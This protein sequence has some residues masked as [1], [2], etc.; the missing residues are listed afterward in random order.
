M[1]PRNSSA[2]LG[3]ACLSAIAGF[4]ALPGCSKA[5][6][7]APAI[8]VRLATGTTKAGDDVLVQLS[9]T[10]QSASAVLVGF[11]SAVH[12]AQDTW[13]TNFDIRP[14]FV[15]MAGPG[16]TASAVTLAAREGVI[17]A[18]SPLQVPRPFQLEPV[19]FPSRTGIAG[20]VDDT[21][22]RLV[23]F[24]DGS[25]RE[26]YLGRSFFVSSPW[27]DLQTGPG[28]AANGTHPVRSDWSGGIRVRDLTTS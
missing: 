4:C 5:K 7:P 19:C 28:G 27:I 2:R 10:N 22:D 18:W 15:G 14:R 25:P 11:R 12:R 21:Q 20:V 26:S 24:K 16:S 13:V 3:T 23:Q 1:L 9:I 6:G 17:A 8:A